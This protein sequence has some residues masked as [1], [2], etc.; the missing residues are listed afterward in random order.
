MG[1]SSCSL[2]IPKTSN[3]NSDNRNLES[4]IT[5]TS[6]TMNEDASDEHRYMA[7]GNDYEYY[8]FSFPFEITM[9]LYLSPAAPVTY[10]NQ[11][12]VYMYAYDISEYEA[13]IGDYYDFIGGYEIKVK[14]YQTG[15]YNYGDEQ[16]YDIYVEY[17]E[18]W[19]S[20][21]FHVRRQFY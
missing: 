17:F 1:L 6:S 8:A 10:K 9:Y 15:F 4:D 5:P 20:A 14:I 18:S 19:T 11:M 7:I 3:G 13:E 21:N 2:L 12:L 16:S